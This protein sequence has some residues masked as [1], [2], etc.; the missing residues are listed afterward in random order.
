MAQKGENALRSGAFSDAGIFFR[1]AQNELENLEF[2][3]R[4]S[5]NN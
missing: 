3:I 4:K 2:T 1:K 5:C